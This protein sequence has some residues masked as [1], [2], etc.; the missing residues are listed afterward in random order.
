MRLSEASVRSR[1]ACH[2][3]S[4]TGSCVDS[5]SVS[6][7]AGRCA[8]PEPRSRRLR[9]C[10]RLGQRNQ[11]SGRLAASAS[12]T[13]RPSPIARASDGTASQRP[14]QDATRNNPVTVSS[15]ARCGQAPSHASANFARRRAC[16]SLSRARASVVRSEVFLA[17]FGS[18][19]TPFNQLSRLPANHPS[20]MAAARHPFEHGIPPV[21]CITRRRD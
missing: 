8:M 3:A 9:P 7:V 13:N 15:R 4:A 11:T 19:V 21:S 2:N 10:S 5:V 17:S 16:V 18:G 6:V 20:T 12:S 14:A 1:C